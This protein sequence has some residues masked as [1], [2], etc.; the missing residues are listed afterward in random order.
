MNRHAR[1]LLHEDPIQHLF[2][3][4]LIQLPRDHLW[5]PELGI[6]KL[7]SYIE[8]RGDCI[9]LHGLRQWNPISILA[10]QREHLEVTAPVR[11]MVQDH[12]PWT[13]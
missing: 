10:S 5:T 3:E 8:R 2:Q 11:L 12:L 1:F 6:L 9:G 7:S 13:A 4:D